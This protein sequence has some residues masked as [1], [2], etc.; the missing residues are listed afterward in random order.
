M[1]GTKI[2]YPLGPTTF[3]G[4]TR[5]NEP[6]PVIRQVPVP[7]GL[8]AAMLGNPVT[9]LILPCVTPASDGNETVNCVDFIRPAPSENVTFPLMVYVE[10]APLAD[11]PDWGLRTNAHP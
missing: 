6:I 1:V 7:S 2:S 10:L 8:S 3:V 11:K 4:T 5:V 9:V